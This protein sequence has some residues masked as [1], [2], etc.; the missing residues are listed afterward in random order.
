MPRSPYSSATG[1]WP[2]RCSRYD[3]APGVT[4]PC[5]RGQSDRRGGQDFP[6]APDFLAFPPNVFKRLV[7]PTHLA[8]ALP[9]AQ[10]WPRSHDCALGRQIGDN[11][12]TVCIDVGPAWAGSPFHWDAEER[13]TALA[14]GAATP[15]PSRASALAQRPG[16]RC[17][18]MVPVPTCNRDSLEQAGL[19]VACR[20]LLAAAT[21][22]KALRVYATRWRCGLHSGE[23]GACRRQHPR[24][25]W[26]VGLLLLQLQHIKPLRSVP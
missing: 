18:A 8:V 22:P 21:T 13:W 4:W 5:C 16:C 20:G 7:Q 6:P 19:G 14:H 24:D 10:R 23:V 1:G 15:M 17:A 2:P 9:G 12:T 3:A 25:G 11:I 26:G